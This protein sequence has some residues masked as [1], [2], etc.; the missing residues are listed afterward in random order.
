MVA[1]VT[2]SLPRVARRAVAGSNGFVHLRLVVCCDVVAGGCAWRA[3]ASLGGPFASDAGTT[4]VSALCTAARSAETL[5]P[6]V[7]LTGMNASTVGGQDVAY[8]SDLIGR[9]YSLC[10]GCHVDGS[11]GDRHIKQERPGRVHRRLRRELAGAVIERRSGRR[12][13]PQPGKAWSTRSRRGRSGASTSSTYANA[14][15]AAG[16]PRN[17]FAVDGGDMRRRG[18]ATAELHVQPAV[19]AAMTNI[20]NCVP[21]PALFASSD[22]GHHGVAGRVF[23]HRQRAAEDA[24]RDRPD[25]ARLRGAGAGPA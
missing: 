4:T 14:W 5:I 24:R 2:R 7:D 11:R 15:L 16:K 20:G 6:R 9:F 18:S 17:V 10:G 12:R 13:C 23:R 1:C 8:T 22:V 21:S 3:T 19:A 25:H